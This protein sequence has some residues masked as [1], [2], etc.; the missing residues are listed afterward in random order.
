MSLRSAVAGLAVAIM[1]AGCG[2]ASPPEASKPPERWPSNLQELHFVWSA[3]PGIDLLTGPA[4]IARAYTESS[5]IAF[6]GGSLDY[7]YPGFDHAVAQNQPVGS[8]RS[9]IALWPEPETDPTPVVGTAQ[10]HILRI[11]RNGRDVAVVTCYWTWGLALQQPN[12][13]YQIGAVKPGAYAGVFAN[14]I[15]LLAPTEQG[16]LPPQRGP[17][18]YPLVDVFGAWRVVGSLEP[19]GSTD[20]LP[21]WPERT[22][23]YETC[24]AKAP[25]P[26]ERREFL[27]TGDHPRSEF[28]T[29]PAYPGWPPQTQQDPKK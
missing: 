16:V 15:N 21:E 24:A 27:T 25:T 22:Q 11:D 7:L 26:V 12:G 2:H 1:V 4:V 13:Q 20:A 14:R 28:P 3:E 8:P 17:S 18:T 19:M 23:D 9:T 10:E 6:W 5:M 29:L